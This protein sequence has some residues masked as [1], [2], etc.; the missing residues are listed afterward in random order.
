MKKAKHFCGSY[1]GPNVNYLCA[2]HDLQCDSCKLK[3]AQA[4][5]D[6]T[7]QAAKDLIDEISFVKSH[8]LSPTCESPDLATLFSDLEVKVSQLKDAHSNFGQI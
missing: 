8:V 7:E 5:I 1:F 4:K 2:E 6:E 3:D